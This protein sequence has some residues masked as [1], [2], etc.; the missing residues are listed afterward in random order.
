M[1]ILAIESSAVS[2]S[3]ALGEDSKIVASEFVNNGYTH[4]QTLMPMVKRVLDKA[5]ISA[6]DIDMY[7]VTN[8]PGSFT[9][10]RIG[11]ATVKGLAFAEN[12][13]CV[14]V[15]TLE[16]IA[17]NLSG[18]DCIAVAAMDARRNQIYT[19]T[20]DCDGTGITR[21]TEDEAL[22][23]SALINRINAYNKPVYFSGDGAGKAYEQL[24]PFCKDIFLPEK[25][26]IFQNAEQVC[27]LA[28]LRKEEAD[29]AKKLVPSYLRMSQAQRELK[30]KRGEL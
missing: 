4:S 9:G 25:D 27:K 7:A 13:R 6:A 5:K 29:S 30:R 1:K 18:T 21:L 3:V 24:K 20:F 23:I 28:F 14:G 15:S 17:M 19:A 2:A 16:A 12:K 26:K 10:V 8:G 11:V 22:P